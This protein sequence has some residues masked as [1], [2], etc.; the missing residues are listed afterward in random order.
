[1]KAGEAE[2]NPFE[3]KPDPSLFDSLLNKLPKLGELPKPGVFKKKEKSKK[4]KNKTDDYSSADTD[5]YDYEDDDWEESGPLLGYNKWDED[6]YYDEDEYE[7][8]DED[9]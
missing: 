9:W 3:K 8:E 6:E 4:D 5:S 7:D 2:E 1:E